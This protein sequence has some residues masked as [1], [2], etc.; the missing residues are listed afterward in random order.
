MALSLSVLEVVSTPAVVLPDE[1]LIRDASD[2]PIL[3]SAIREKA[4]ILITGDKDFLES[5][6]T[7]PRI[8]TAAEF[9]KMG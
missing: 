5:K 7:K 4:D 9:L 8:M 2:R 3:R 1:A 6:V